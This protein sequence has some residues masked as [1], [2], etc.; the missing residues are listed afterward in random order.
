MS[1][2]IQNLGV[3]DQKNSPAIWQ[4]PL[5]QFPVNF[6]NGRILIDSDAGNLY[7]DTDINRN[8]I[9]QYTGDLL[10]QNGL[11]YAASSVI[12]DASIIELG[13]SLVSDT[14]INLNTHTF[15]FDGSATTTKIRNTGYLQIGGSD[16][17]TAQSVAAG[18]AITNKIANIKIGSQSF[19]INVL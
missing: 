3:I 15:E 17:I 16:V 12:G 6:V 11:T 10:I 7:L 4:S 13:G 5:A 2:G 14:A 1:F 18:V 9:F 19:Q 8:L